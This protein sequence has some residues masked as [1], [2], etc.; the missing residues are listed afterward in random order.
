MYILRLVPLFVLAALLSACVSAPETGRSQVL[1]IDRAQ[2]A[3]MG[4]QAFEKM[5]REKPVVRGG[6]DWARLQKVGRRIARVVMEHDIIAVAV[7]TA[8]GS[9]GAIDTGFEFL[10]DV[11]GYTIDLV[12]QQFN[13]D[14]DNYRQLVGLNTG[15]RRRMSELSAL[16]TYLQFTQ[17]E[18]EGQEER[19]ADSVSIRRR[20][21]SHSC[22]ERLLTADYP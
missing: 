12:G 9:L 20:G 22:R 11:N 6:K 5:K 21:R 3:R 19:D 17:L 14:D 16:Q 13:L 18:Y 4:F 8:V 7:E 10:H 1:L 15:W 2:E